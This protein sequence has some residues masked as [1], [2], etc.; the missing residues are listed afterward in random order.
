MAR[1]HV[2][3]L[4]PEVGQFASAAAA[5]Y[6]TTPAAD[7]PLDHPP[8]TIR[9]PCRNT[10]TGMYETQTIAAQ[11]LRELLDDSD[12][13]DWDE[14]LAATRALMKAIAAGKPMTRK[15]ARIVAE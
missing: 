14:L 8:S 13:D 10:F 1:W 11:A 5:G 2:A 9:Q 6:Q 7:P 12:R 3:P 4:C 15:N